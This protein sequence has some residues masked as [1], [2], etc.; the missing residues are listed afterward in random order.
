[1]KR[2]LTHN[3]GWKALSLAAAVL[4]WISV[5]TEP[6][7]S[8]FVSA[9]V[10]YKNLA[11]DVEINSDVVETV[12]LEVR[13][14]SGELRGLPETRRQYAVILD[15]TNIGPGQHTF[16]I[17][18]GDARVPRGIQL[19]RA[20]PSQIRMELE[21]SDTRSVPVDV[22][23]ANTL[24]P[25]MHVVEAVAEP[26]VLAVSGPASRVA[27]IASAQTDPI[28]VRPEAGSAE[29]RVA[30]YVNDPRVRLRSAPQ[31][32]VKVTVERK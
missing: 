28:D 13:G 20:I 27:H 23:F 31:V 22:R 6:E 26:S 5:A 16:A 19:V 11:P 7:L 24:P 10:E 18:R 17:D 4:L 15:M 30:A 29:Y 12:F 3:A 2:F 1:M 8:T 32:T 21:R 9:R 14:P 25:E